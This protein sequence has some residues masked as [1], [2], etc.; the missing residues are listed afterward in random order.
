MIYELQ[1]VHY[2]NF[3]HEFNHKKEIA[4]E[5][6]EIKLH[7]GQSR[8]SDCKLFIILNLTIEFNTHKN[9]NLPI[10]QKLKFTYNE[11]S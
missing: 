9:K 1:T 7:D 10:L 5:A 2:L 8:P 6:K 11:Q 4:N 3:S